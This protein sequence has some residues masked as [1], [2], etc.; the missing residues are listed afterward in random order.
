MSNS[1]SSGDYKI[2]KLLNVCSMTLDNNFPSKLPHCIDTCVWESIHIR[3][4]T[5]KLSRCCHSTTVNKTP[6]GWELRPKEANHMLAATFMALCFY[7]CI[8]IQCILVSL[9]SAIMLH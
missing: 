8:D 4:V 6:N 9:N 2:F 5:V 7:T 1:I 3:N